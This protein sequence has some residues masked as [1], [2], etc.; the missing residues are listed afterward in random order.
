MAPAPRVWRGPV[1]R[2]AGRGYNPPRPPRQAGL[3]GRTPA[4][5]I[6]SA[7]SPHPASEK[8]H[9][10][11]FAPV[12]SWLGL[13]PGPWP[14]DHY[15]LLGMS[16]GSADP[17]AVEA[18][19]M[20]RMELLRRH[21]L[22]NPDLVTEGM[23]RL[24][25][26][27]ITLT[28]P[29]GKDAYDA[30][31]GVRDRSPG[32]EHAAAPRGRADERALE[33]APTPPTD[34]IFSDDHVAA[35]EP[36]E[37]DATRVLRTLPEIGDASTTYDVL[38][39]E[40]V[41]D[42]T[43]LPLDAGDDAAVPADDGGAV[44]LDAVAVAAPDGL[45]ARRWIYARLALLRRT[46]RAWERLGPVFGDPEDP[47]DRPGRV[48]LLLDATRTLRPLLP[49]LRGVAGG[50]GGAG[51]VVA[52]LAQYPLVL[53]TF[54]RLLPSQRRTL[55]IDWRRGHSALTREYARL[56]QLAAVGRNRLAGGRVGVAAVRWV[57]GTPEV[58]LVVG[59]VIALVVAVVRTA[60]YR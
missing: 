9:R 1:R 25:Q 24:A 51:G 6:P 32:P 37:G 30:A 22:R 56:R 16:P 5:K 53:D 2:R 7:A 11:D 58:V 35:A 34:D 26:A 12:R 23:N 40:V 28:D 17:A 52:A 46:I 48:L 4:P 45:V 3:P 44:V 36:T 38:P 13:A 54:R 33:V 41:P 18:R 55:A 60:A 57:M 14:P 42:A 21:Q 27:L 39:Y 15:A 20:E 50:V 19:V 49:Q 31:L 8:P 43:R 59:A 47:V 10:V 29:A